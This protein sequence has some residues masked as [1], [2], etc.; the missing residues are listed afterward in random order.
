MNPLAK[1]DQLNLEPAAKSEVAAMLQALID[2]AAQDAKVIQAKDATLHAKDIKIGALTHELAYY[3]RIRFSRKNESLAPLQRD[4]FEETWN[5]DISAIDEEVEQL[6]DDQPCDTVARPKRPRAGRQPLP[7]HLPR[8]EHRHEPASCTCGQCGKD[9]VKIGEDIT[10]QLD[11]E[12]A[13]FFVHRHIRPQYA[14]RACESITAAAIPPAVID[15][16][17]A[18]VGLLTWVLIGKYLDHLPL[19]RLEQIAARDGVIL[20]RS[21]LADWVGRLGVALQP[22]ADRLAWQV[23]QRDSLHADETPVPQLDPGSGKTKKAYLWAYRSNDLQPG[24][25]II[26]FDYQA[27]RGGRYAQQ[28]LGDWHGHLVV[29]D[30]AGYKALFAATRAHPASQRLLEPCV[31]LAC[32]AHARRKFFD[33]FQASQSPIAQE[34]LKRIAKLYAVEALAR[35]V[36][37]EARK[38]LRVEISLPIL[39]ELHDWLQQT[40][41][42]TAPNS[43]TAKAIDYSLKRWV[44][45]SRYAQT[46]DL[47]IDNNPV[48][49]SIR[50]IALGKK[51]WLFAGSERAGQR[52]AVIQTLLGTA[53]LNGLDPAAWLKDTLEKLPTWPNSRI[54]ELLPFSHRD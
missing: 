16:G 44:A 10:E 37:T 47:P 7:D 51:N 17:M 1:L 46:G 45:L 15:G 8:F 34:A 48:E 14:C 32:L 35:D 43:A 49:N 36:S 21:T 39:A 2:Q 40:R 53:K 3:R 29:D 30:Y 25:K 50:P 38:Q 41:L 24:P 23:L 4:V 11:V 9:L 27:G 26:V 33:L 12:P 22:L 18:A 42:R 13:K 31:E 20:S 6:R 54:D 28:F 52:A 19:Y 5:T